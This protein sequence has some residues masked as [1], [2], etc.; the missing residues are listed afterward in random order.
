MGIYGLGNVRTVHDYEVFGGFDFKKL[1]IQ[2]YT[3]KVKEPPNPIP[4]ED[5]FILNKFD[6]VCEWDIEF[7]KK[8]EFKNP[9]FMTFAIH[10]NSG[11]EI[12]R[13]DFTIEENPQYVNLENNKIT[14]NIE[15]IDK[16]GKIVMY[17][18]DEDKQ[19]SDRYE[20]NI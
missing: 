14:V 13:K 10:T 3:L 16:P 17:L 1:I 4:W 11:L 20:K 12:Y 19:W 5:Q 6:L 9:K 2:D 7:F 15:S 18:F 8:H